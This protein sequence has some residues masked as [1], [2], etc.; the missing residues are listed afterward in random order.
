[1]H[2][3]GD[4]Q[5]ER[6]AAGAWQFFAP[7]KTAFPPSLAVMHRSG[8]VQDER[9]ASAPCVACIPAVPGGRMPRVHG[10]FLLLQKLHSR[11]PWRSTINCS[12]VFAFPPS[13]AVMH[14]SGDVQDE[15]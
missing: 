12:C 9:Q 6:Y 5:D 15:R 2:R 11:H 10:S 3:S 4:V 8:D 7:A 13:M 1:M 14:R